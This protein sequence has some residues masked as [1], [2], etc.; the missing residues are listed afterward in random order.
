MGDAGPI[1]VVAMDDHDRAGRGMAGWVA[2]GAGLA[3][4]GTAASARQ[5]LALVERV[6]P[7]VATIGTGLPDLDGLALAGTLRERYPD[8]GLILVLAEPD[9]ARGAAAPPQGMAGAHPR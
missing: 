1:R 2:H 4:A 9:P 3:L 5:A 8:L 7:T 6:R